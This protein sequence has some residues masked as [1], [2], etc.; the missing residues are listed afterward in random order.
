MEVKRLA[1]GE[2]EGDVFSDVWI[3]DGVPFE[4]RCAAICGEEARWV[5][6]GATSGKMA[7]EL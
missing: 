2:S 6:R 7:R 3:I 1:C 4:K 5:K